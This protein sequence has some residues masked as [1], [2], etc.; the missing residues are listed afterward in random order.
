MRLKLIRYDES[1]IIKTAYRGDLRS[2]KCDNVISTSFNPYLR[3]YFQY[4]WWKGNKTYCVDFEKF[5]EEISMV[6]F[7]TYLKKIDERFDKIVIIK[8]PYPA[9][10]TEMEIRFVFD[11]PREFELEEIGEEECERITSQ[12]NPLDLAKEIKDQKLYTVTDLNLLISQDIFPNI[13]TKIQN[14]YPSILRIINEYDQ[15]IIRIARSL[16]PK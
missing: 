5:F 16:T 6:I 2:I 10:F 15:R 12:V 14:E 4:P 9:C 7:F 3:K 8:Y 11:S 1:P 13:L